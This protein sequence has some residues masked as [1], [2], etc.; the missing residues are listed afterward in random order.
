[1]AE[2]AKKVIALVNPK[3]PRPHGDG[4]IHFS[5]FTAAV[6]AEDELPEMRITPPT[7]AEIAIGKCIASI[8]EDGSTLQMGIGGIP[9]AVLH[10][11]MDHKDLGVHTEMFTDAILPLVEKG[12][13]NGRRKRKHPGKIVSA[14]ALGTRKLF[15]FIH[16]NPTVAM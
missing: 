3:M 14:F 10:S 11:L 9:G 8:V 7:D 1:A 13:I 12:I 6:Y 4:S 2:T 15:D 5:R 16:D